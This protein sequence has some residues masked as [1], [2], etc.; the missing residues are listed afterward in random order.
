M[1][2][3]VIHLSV[4]YLMNIDGAAKNQMFIK[5]YDFWLNF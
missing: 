3:S 2:L 1:L 5:S 4:S